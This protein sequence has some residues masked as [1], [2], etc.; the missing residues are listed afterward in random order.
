MKIEYFI[1]ENNI[2]IAV[3]NPSKSPFRPIRGQS[4]WQH[5]DNDT[6]TQMRSLHYDHICNCCRHGKKAAK[7]KK[8]FSYR[9]KLFYHAAVGLRVVVYECLYHGIRYYIQ[10]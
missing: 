4:R 5:K 3:S 6:Q 9:L 10:C 7:S 1:K 2:S 8:T